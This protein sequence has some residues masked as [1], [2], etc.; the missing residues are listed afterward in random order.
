M[1]GQFIYA[2]SRAAGLRVNAIIRNTSRVLNSSAEQSDMRIEILVYQCGKEIYK[3]TSYSLIKHGDF[4]E[5]NEKDLPLSANVNHEGLIIVCCSRGEGNGYFPQEHQLNYESIESPSKMASVVY[6]QLPVISSELAKPRP[7]L[8]LASKVWLSSKL[9]TY[10]S[11]ANSTPN[12]SEKK[13]IW[14]I[15]LLDC[16]GS[17]VQKFQLKNS[18]NDAKILSVKSM[19]KKTVSVSDEM[20][21]F[22]LVARGE[23]VSSV[24]LTF[25]TDEAKG[26][27]AVEH[28]LSPHYYINGD[29]SRVRKEAFIFQKDMWP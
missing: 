16:S 10:I 27:F 3:N 5:I 18:E 29:F 11:F 2:T 8:L 14:D 25:L 24:L 4:L 15:S 19:L 9:N 6:D 21:M 17:M 28:S 26:S 7:I 23:A 12:Q 1:Q 22:T 20:E 13:V